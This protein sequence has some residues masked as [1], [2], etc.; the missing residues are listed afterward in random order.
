MEFQSPNFTKLVKFVSER[1][2]GERIDH[3]DGWDKCALGLCFGAEEVVNAA[4]GPLFTGM[5]I[6]TAL[7]LPLSIVLALGD[8]SPPETYGELMALIEEEYAATEVL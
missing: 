1:N 8:F 5:N 4:D 6:A 2:P 3:A 7:D